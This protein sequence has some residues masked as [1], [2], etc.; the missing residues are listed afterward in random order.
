L[1]TL[2]R[3]P[4]RAFSRST[5]STGLSGTYLGVERTVDV[6]IMNLRRKIEPEPGRPVYV[7]TV[8]GVGYK[9]RGARSRTGNWREQG[10]QKGY[11]VA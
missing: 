5:S 10:R 2:V 8:P 11:D 6:H 3:E 9:V 4:G 1:E 7:L